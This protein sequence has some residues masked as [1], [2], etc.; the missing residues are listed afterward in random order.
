MKNNIK[1][2]KLGDLLNELSILKDI[3]VSDI[4]INLEYLPNF[5][6]GIHEKS[7]ILNKSIPEN[8]T[9]NIALKDLDLNYTVIS[10]LSNV[11][12]DGLTI[13]DHT[14][15][16]KKHFLQKQGLNWDRTYII[17]PKEDIPNMMYNFDLDDF[18]DSN[19]YDD[20]F[21]QAITHCKSYE[22]TLKR[23]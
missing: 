12:A 3:K 7:D 23:R 19:T 2:V 11:C 6:Y 22:K 21:A 18:L 17:I 1:T 9:L 15:I 5:V 14:K 10:D 13:Y 20:T 16:I 8:L 4:E